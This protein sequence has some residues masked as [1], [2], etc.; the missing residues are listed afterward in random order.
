[1][2]KHDWFAPYLAL[3]A[4]LGVITARMLLALLSAAFWQF[5]VG[6]LLVGALTACMLAMAPHPPPEIARALEPSERER[7]PYNLRSR[8][9]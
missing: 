7:E 8:D 3:A 6:F 1:M 9:K 4:V 2:T 5:A